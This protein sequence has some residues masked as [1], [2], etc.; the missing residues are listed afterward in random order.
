[1]TKSMTIKIIILSIQNKYKKSMTTEQR[2]LAKNF[3]QY[4][5][6]LF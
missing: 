6:R 1:M 2:V 3:D 5:F 4:Q